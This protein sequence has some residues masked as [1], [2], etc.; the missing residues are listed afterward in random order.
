M[1][2]KQILDEIAN[3]PSTNNKMTI[4]RKYE[5]NN[6]LKRVLYMAKSKRLKYYI[7]QIPEY[8]IPAL[9]PKM[10][11]EEALE[12]L[13]PLLERTVTGHE[14][15]KHLATILGS[16]ESDDAYVIER[17]IDRSLKIDMGTSNINKV[18][19]ALIE[20]TPYMGAKSFDEK[21]V[22]KLFD[23]VQVDPKLAGKRVYSQIKEDGRYA[24]AIIRD[25][26]A[27]FESRSGETTHV[28]DAL[29]LKELAQ[30]GDCV[31]NGELTIKGLDRYTANGIIA[32]IVDIEGKRESRTETETSKKLTKFEGKHGNYPEMLNRIEYVIWDW[33]PVSAYFDQKCNIPYRV[34]L[35]C[36]LELKTLYKITLVR[37][38]ETIQ[39]DTYAEAM[40]HFVN[41]LDRGLE[42]TIV[43]A[44]DSTWKHGKPNWQVKMKLELTLDFRIIGFNYGNKGTKNENV[45][46]T[47]QVES[48]CG[49]LKTNPSG[50]DEEMMQFVTDNQ[51]TLMGTVV[52]MRCCGLSQDSKGNWST[53]HPSVVKL[54][55]DKDVCDTLETAKQVE[56]MAKSLET[57]V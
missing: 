29:V 45:I 12:E 14:A 24:N 57:E 11:L 55:D 46:S 52:E 33:I 23:G 31:L 20:K 26:E 3:E 34:R 4:L 2:I 21:L 10:T 28:G 39:V 22:R 56:E 36:V 27:E 30:F 1:K 44:S 19:P 53:M 49:L 51:D 16:L 15:I 9:Y 38:V 42:G 5:E 37:V 8:I 17:I 48:E 50:M 25:G 40:E 7:K 6:T 18:F 54:R 41:A 13:T 35:D 47:L 32:S 43:K